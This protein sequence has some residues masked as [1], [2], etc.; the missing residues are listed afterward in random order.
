[1]HID[2][3]IYGG[4]KSKAVDGSKAKAKDATRVY[5]G[6]RRMSMARGSFTAGRYVIPSNTHLLEIPPE[7]LKR[8]TQRFFHL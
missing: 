5:V 2:M 3:C 6:S 1:M 8:E 4:E 7:S